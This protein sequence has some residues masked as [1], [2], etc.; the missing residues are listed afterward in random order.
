[1]GGCDRGF[2]MSAVL[3]LQS[4][5][6]DLPQTEP[7]TDHYFASGMYGRTMAMPKGMVVVGKKHKKEHFFIVTKG[8]VVVADGD[9]K[10]AMS[11][12]EVHISKPGAKRAIVAVEDSIIMTVHK[13]KKRNLDALETQLIEPEK[14]ASLMDAR[15]KVKELI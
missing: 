7:V 6:M 9:E 15:N 2:G 1:M 5:M 14:I 3:R 11:A 12:G 13:T 8:R 10:R 4:A